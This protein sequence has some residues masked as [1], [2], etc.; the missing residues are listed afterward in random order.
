M[1]ET[2]VQPGGMLSDRRARMIT[3]GVI[4]AVMLALFATNIMQTIFLC[5]D[6]FISFRYSRHFA[7]GNGL[8]WNVGERV[9]GYSNF[10]WVIM[11]GILMKVGIQPEISSL[12][13]GV[14]SGLALLA[15]VVAFSGR[16]Y[17]WANP[18]MWFAPLALASN[19]SFTAWSTGG[20]ETM[21][22]SFLIFLGLASLL[23]ARGKS[24][25]SRWILASSVVF[26]LASLTRPDAPLFAGLG[27]AFFFGDKIIRERR[28]PFREAMTWALPYIAIVGMHYIWRFS[29]YGVWFPNTY[30][31]KV[32][33][34]W[35]EQGFR[36]LD[37]F[38]DSYSIYYTIPLLILALVW[39]PRLESLTF[40]GIII[41]WGAYVAKIGGDWMENRMLIVLYPMLYWLIGEGL[42]RLSAMRMASINPR[43][44]QVVAVVCAV[45]LLGLTYQGNRSSVSFSAV[46]SA[47][48][49][50]SEDAAARRIA[51]VNALRFYA[52]IRS[53][54]GKFLRDLVDEGLLPD[55]LIFGV[56]GAGALPYYVMWPSVDFIGLTDAQV[57]RQEASSSPAGFVM[58]GHEK[59]ASID[60]LRERQVVMLDALN[61]IV[62]DA[63]FDPDNDPFK[64]VRI[65]V[66]PD[67]KLRTVKVKDKYLVFASLVPEEV[68]QQTFGHLEIIE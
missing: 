40:A 53:E 3:T 1:S 66:L 22:Y 46:A 39:R 56:G 15:T 64:A 4:V 23:E 17:G 41:G 31:A 65:M 48:E 21:F 7:D 54:Q 55:D 37:L 35:W 34:P 12:V 52:F 26:A 11:L 25:P 20:L 51:T 38:A 36:Y 49:M 32:N 5:D 30:Y 44:P 24:S 18:W 45:V 27:V 9:E 6:A 13:F 8:V 62:F 16:R 58:A 42:S 50:L 67:V 68:F 10:L 2:E 57:A 14:L 19:P 63:P 59:W 29:Y 28:I 61:Q 33:K 60:Y 47:E 43:W